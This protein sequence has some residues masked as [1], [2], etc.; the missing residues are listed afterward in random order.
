MN[1]NPNVEVE[2][3]TEAQLQQTIQ[4]LSDKVLNVTKKALA[5]SN[6][7]L[8]PYGLKLEMHVAIKQVGEAGE[9]PKEPE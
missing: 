6:L 5:D 3:L 2:A 4:E 8:A 1:E 9:T 7:A